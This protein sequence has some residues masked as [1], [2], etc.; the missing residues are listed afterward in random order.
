MWNWR[1]FIKWKVLLWHVST[2]HIFFISVKNR[3]NCSLMIQ[4]Y[5]V[6]NTYKILFV[7]LFYLS[8][9]RFSIACL[10]SIFLVYNIYLYEIDSSSKLHYI[11]NFLSR[12]SDGFIA[13]QNYALNLIDI[14][15]CENYEKK[16]TTEVDKPEKGGAALTTSCLA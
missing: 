10:I 11:L 13:T 16:N 4:A 5:N 3:R 12:N 1:K 8:K 7:C 2:V 14:Y 6:Q 15:G 9:C